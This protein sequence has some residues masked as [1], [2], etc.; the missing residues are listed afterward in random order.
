MSVD[1]RNGGYTQERHPAVSQQ[2][3]EKLRT[4]PA[5]RSA[6]LS[7]VPLVGLRRWSNELLI[8]G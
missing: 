5:V 4:T 1:I 6:S 7:F 3:L 8:E 2:M